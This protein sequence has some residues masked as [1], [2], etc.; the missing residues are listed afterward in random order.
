[1]SNTLGKAFSV[2]SF[3]ESHGQLVG[4]VVDGC[5][6]G[7]ALDEEDIQLE[8][9]KRKADKP[10]STSRQEPDRAEIL[11][12][13][14][15][16]RTTGAPITMVIYNQDFDSSKYGERMV[17]PRPGHADY[18]SFIKYKGFS[19]HRGGGR[20]SG[21]I[22]AGF[23]MS[24]AVAKKLLALSDIEVL[25]HTIEI[26]GIK[27][28]QAS[29]EE[30]RSSSKNTL[31]CADSGASLNMLE[32]INQAKAEGDSLG[33]I[34]EAIALGVPAGLGEPVFDN[35]DG[36]LAK[37][38]FAIPAVKAVEFGAGFG[39]ARMKGSQ[40]NDPIIVSEKGITCATN[41]AG[42]VTGGMSNGMPIVMRIAIK[43]TP[44][45]SIEQDS[46]NVKT[47]QPEKL[48]VTGRHDTCIVPRAV[49]VIEA[50]VAITLADFAIRAR[51]IPGVVE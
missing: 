51:I 15:Q 35:I 33:G 32:A 45:V 19:D 17:I 38:I 28:K 21:R 39:A 9:N 43:P 4:V 7:L 25:A 24:G 26:G 41:N 22:T 37:A 34:V 29:L 14:Y 16:G 49:V 3:G 13:V 40:N 6:P 11:S 27:T 30:I 8:L 18:A 23:V 2:T 42:G 50:M 46:V 12:G 5:P 44:S 10:G 31:C 1:M 36:D 20:F 47:L 48:A